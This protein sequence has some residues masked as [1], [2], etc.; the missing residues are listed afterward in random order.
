MEPLAASLGPVPSLPVFAA[1]LTPSE[2]RDSSQ[3]QAPSQE[4][5]VELLPDRVDANDPGHSSQRRA[6]EQKAEEEKPLGLAG[7][8]SQQPKQEIDLSAIGGAKNHGVTYEVRSD[9]SI[10]FQGQVVDR[11]NNE[12]VKSIPTDARVEVAERYQQYIGSR[13]DVEA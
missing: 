3:A 12:T 11:N 5:P 7:A 4:R 1:P 9:L 10:R 2:Q 6:A 13:L 8:L